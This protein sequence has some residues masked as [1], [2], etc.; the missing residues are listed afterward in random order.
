VG[1]SAFRCGRVAR[2]VSRRK[3]PRIGKAHAFHKVPAEPV[4]AASEPRHGL[5]KDGTIPTSKEEATGVSETVTAVAHEGRK[6][7]RVALARPSKWG[8][9]CEP[10]LPPA[11]FASG[12]PSYPVPAARVFGLVSRSAKKDVSRERARAAR[13]GTRAIPVQGRRKAPCADKESQRWEAAKYGCSSWNV[14][15]CRSRSD[16][17]FDRDAQARYQ[18]RRETR[19]L[20][21]TNRTWRSDAQAATDSE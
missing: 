1:S 15:E 4:S 2:S 9:R 6:R 7:P 16:A 11:S 14:S 19:G 20:A 10:R 12:G 3:A 21:R 5:A 18:A 13:L 17:P 8:S